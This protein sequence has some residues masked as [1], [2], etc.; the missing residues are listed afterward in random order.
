LTFSK[1]HDALKALAEVEPRQAK[2]VEQRY[3][4]GLTVEEIAVATK[5]SP[6]TVKRE[7][8]SAKAWL[9]SY[10]SKPGPK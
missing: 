1:L 5:W 8:A 2:I 7:L 3:F 4:A 10:L 6:A 9:A